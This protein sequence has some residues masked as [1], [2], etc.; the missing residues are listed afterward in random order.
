MDNGWKDIKITGIAKIEKCVGE[1]NVWELHKS[2]Y[3]KFKVKLFES[4]DGGYTGY[5]NLQVADPFGG[6]ECAVGYGKT[7]QE[8]LQNTIEDFLRLVSRKAQWSEQDFRCAD[9]FDF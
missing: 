9:P 8:A 3:G 2:P 6:F 5:S 7:Q 1:F 4:A